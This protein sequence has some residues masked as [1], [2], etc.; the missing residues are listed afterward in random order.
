MSGI[1]NDNTD[2]QSGLVKTP[3]LGPDSGSSDPANDTNPSAVGARFIN[4]TSGELF[5]CTSAT[6]DAN[7]WEGQLDTSI[8]WPPFIGGRGV[9]VGGSADKQVM[10]YVT[11]AT[12]GDATDFGDMTTP[13]YGGAVV[14]NGSRGIYTGGTT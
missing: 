7:A 6:T 2:K 13:R 11:I 3:V 12:T 8:K 14:S 9:W 1:I 5:V 10:D 4:T